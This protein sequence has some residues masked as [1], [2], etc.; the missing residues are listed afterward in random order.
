[1]AEKIPSETIDLIERLMEG[2]LDDAGHARLMELIDKNPAL[3]GRI[4]GHLDISSTLHLAA[5]QEE[6]FASRTASHVIRIAEEG[7]FAF[8]RRVKRRVARGRMVKGLAAAAVLTLAGFHFFYN[9]APRG[10]RVALLLR[11]NH[12]NQVISS[13]PIYSGTVIEETSGLVRL[14]FKNGAVAAVEG[15]MKLKVVSGMAIELESGRMNGWCP[16]TAHGFKVHTKSAVLTDLGTSFGITTTQDGK[17]EFMVLDG[18]VEVEKGDEK[19]RLEEGAAIKSSMDQAMRAVAFD[20]SAFTKTWPF[21]NGILTTRGAVIP[22]PPDTAEKLALLENDKH[23]LVIPERRG[24]PFDHEIQ[25]EITE[26]GTLPGDIS[27]EVRTLSPVSGKRLSSFLIRYN[28]VGVISEEHFLCFEGE[29]TFD[30][31]VLAISC[32]NGPLAHGDPVFSTARWPDPLRGIELSQRLNP[33]DSVT[34]SPDRRTVKLI[35][36]AGASTDDVRVILEDSA[37]GG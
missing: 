34:L 32:L 8:A 4:A 3:L 10:E 21:S 37:N 20:P 18:L 36:Y 29:V 22:A 26:P 24:I 27:G 16:D 1:M 7:E 12:D 9:P 23:I 13:K 28:P 19:I 25:A 35:F 2:T 15:P 33:P 14:D 30:R 11:M 17:S 5:R 31:P 6:D